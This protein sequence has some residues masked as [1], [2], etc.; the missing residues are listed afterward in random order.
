[1]KASEV[2]ALPTNIRERSFDHKGRIYDVVA[3]MSPD[4]GFTV[5]V[6]VMCN[7]KGIYYDYPDGTRASNRHE[8][9]FIGDS[10]NRQILTSDAVS[11]SMEDAER[12]VRA[13]VG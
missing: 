4:S 2:A 10:D 1:M 5:T 13:W 9:W 8:L 7:G 6:D 3:R 11:F 12:L